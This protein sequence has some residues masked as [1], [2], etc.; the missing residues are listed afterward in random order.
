MLARRDAAHR[1]VDLGIERLALG[2][3]LD[4]A[5]APQDRTSDR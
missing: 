2:L 5:E 4:D 1:L 3:D